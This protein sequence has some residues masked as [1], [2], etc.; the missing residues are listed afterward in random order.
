MFPILLVALS[1]FVVCNAIPLSLQVSRRNLVVHESREDAPSGFALSTPASPDSVLSLRLALVQSDTDGLI[2]ALND[3]ANF[4]TPSAATVS[5]VVDWLT[6]NELNAT[7]LSPVGDWLSLDIPVNKANELLA[8]NYSVYVNAQTGLQTIRTLSYSI[9]EDLQEHL[10]L[11]HPTVTFPSN[12]QHAPIFLASPKSVTRDVQ[13]LVNA[14]AV[15]GYGLAAWM[16]P[17]CLQYL[18]NIPISPAT[19]PLNKIAVTGYDEEYAQQADLEKFLA[20]YR[21]NISSTAKFT[22]ESVEG[23]VNP[24]NSSQAGSEANLDTQYVVGL[25]TNVSTQFI[26]V[27]GDFFDALLDTANFLA[28]VDAPPYVLSTSYGDNEDAISQRLA[29]NIC[30]AYAQLGARGI[31]VL[32]SSGDGGVSGNKNSECTSFV[33]TFPSGCPYITSVGATTQLP[34]EIGADFSSGGFSNYWGTPSYQTTAVSA[35]LDKLG[36][37]NTGLFNASGRAYPDVSA[38]GTNFEIYNEGNLLITSGTSCSTPTFASIV[39]LLN[40]QLTT[41]GKSP[42]GFLNP[43]LYS[44]LSS[45]LTDIVDGNNLACSNGTTGFYA[46]E[47]WDPVTGLGTP[48]FTALATALGL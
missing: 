29:I 22:L 19:N 26:S 34:T 42:L 7:V 36:S 14:T 27:G 17:G 11:V 9:P 8:A 40:D 13:D 1:S 6:E 20:D 15:C 28:G 16:N 3:V 30:N 31:S 46:T 43:L 18:Y 38:Y 33:P 21:P 37:N 2:S 23:G 35:Y 4:V 25:A 41:A 32:F 10:A 24:Q 48:N 47:G 44:N 45:S 12:K 39:A 5:A